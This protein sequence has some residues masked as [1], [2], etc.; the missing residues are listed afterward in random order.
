MLYLYLFGSLA[1]ANPAETEAEGFADGCHET[2]EAGAPA[3]LHTA[4]VDGQNPESW[5][6]VVD[7]EECNAGKLTTPV[8]GNPATT[9]YGQQLVT[10]R[11][12]TRKTS[13][14]I[15]EFRP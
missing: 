15:Y 12:A 11:L 2:L 5:G 7:V 13:A 9:Q 3:L 4:T 1:D 14:M 6:E 8:Q 10:A